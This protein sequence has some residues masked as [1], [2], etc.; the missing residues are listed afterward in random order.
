MR[1]VSHVRFS[2]DARRTESGRPRRAPVGPGRLGRSSPIRRSLKGKEKG[3]ERV[4]ARLPAGLAPDRPTV[5][6]VSPTPHIQRGVQASHPPLRKTSSCTRRFTLEQRVPARGLPFNLGAGLE[7]SP[8]GRQ[9]EGDGQLGRVVGDD[10]GRVGN[11][12]KCRGQNVKE[13]FPEVAHLDAALSEG[14]QVEV[15]VARGQAP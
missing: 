7:E 8:G 9:Q 14:L 6:P 12:R 13:S 11:L 5:A 10:V 15:V 1:G 3:I 4:A 2:A